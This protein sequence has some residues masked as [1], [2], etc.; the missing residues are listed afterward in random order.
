MA[1]GD[2][3]EPGR[4]RAVALQHR[5]S[6]LFGALAGWKHAGADRRGVDFPGCVHRGGVHQP[7]Q[8]GRRADFRDGQRAGSDEERAL[9]IQGTV[10]ALLLGSSLALTALCYLLCGRCSFSSARAEDS[11][12]FADAYLKIVI[13]WARRSP[14]WP[15]DEPVYQRAG[16]PQDRHDDHG[17][18]RG[19]ESGARSAVHLWV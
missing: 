12:V 11:F 5:G 19:A 4:N 9:Q 8:L 18:R 17:D 13:C 6:H 1:Q 16:P 14:C 15:R 7:V 2:S 3:A 10:F